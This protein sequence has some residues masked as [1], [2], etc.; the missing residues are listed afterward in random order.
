MRNDVRAIVR[1]SRRWHLRSGCPP[2]SGRPDGFAQA[3]PAKA[4]SLIVPFAPGGPTDAVGRAMAQHLTTALGQQVFV[5]NRPGAGG[6]IALRR[7]GGRRADGYALLLPTT[8]TLGVRQSLSIPGVDPLRSCAPIGPARHR[9]GFSS[10]FILS[11]RA[12]VERLIALARRNRDSSTSAPR[13]RDAVPCRLAE[14][15]KTAAG[16]H[17]V[18][19]PFGQPPRS[20]IWL[21]GAS[22]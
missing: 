6:T 15:F 8:S 20:S 19:V 16:V 10:S 21:P 4:I 9:S 22:R 14:M 7:I 2:C 18:H 3:W 17:V 1:G 12:V 11:A 13:Q 5:D